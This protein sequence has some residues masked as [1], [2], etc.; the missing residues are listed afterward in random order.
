MIDLKS[1]SEKTAMVVVVSDTFGNNIR[2][3]ISHLT[4]IHD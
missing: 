4:S 1:I 3:N 2:N